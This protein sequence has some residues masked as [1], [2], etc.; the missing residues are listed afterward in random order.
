MWA[1]LHQMEH[2]AHI[3][4]WRP[5]KNCTNWHVAIFYRRLQKFQPPDMA[6]SKIFYPHIQA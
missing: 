6:V 1:F 5:M 2:F 3:W 4:E